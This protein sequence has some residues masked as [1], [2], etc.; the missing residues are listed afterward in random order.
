MRTRRPRSQDK[1]E[2][3]EEGTKKMITFMTKV[4]TFSLSEKNAGT[5]QAINI[6]DLS[7]YI[8]YDKREGKM[9]DILTYKSGKFYFCHETEMVIVD[10]LLFKANLLYE[11]VT[12]LPILP[13]MSA[14]LDPKI[15]YSSISGTAMIEGNP[16]E[17]EGVK[18]IAAGEE[19]PLYTQKDKQEIKN[20]LSL[21]QILSEMEPQN[22][23]LI[24]SEDFIKTMHRIITTEIPHEYNIPGAYRNGEVIVGDKGHGGVYRPPKILADV[25]MLMKEFVAWLNSEEILGLNPF[26]RAALAHYH[27]C[28]IHPFW[29]GNGRTARFLESCLLHSANIKYVPKELSNYYYRNVDDYYAAFSKS[30]KNRKDVTPFIQFM[31]EGVVESLMDIKE[32]ITFLIRRFALRDFYTHEQKNR[33]ISKRQFAL[34]S[35]LL[36]NPIAFTLKDLMDNYPFKIL[37]Q[38]ASEQTAR[39]DIKKLLEKN[40]LKEDDAKKYE[41]NYRALG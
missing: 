20:L 11:T 15:M 1:F 30:I 2:C 18:K 6:I 37:Y 41:L 38:K 19:M 13:G 16:I 17:E 31:L 3:Y 25:K 10:N 9:K 12:D 35:L 8:F 14:R 4:V 29:D 26:L 33:A 22:G 34:L 5:L 7:C 21:Y 40:L 36:D 32:S 28:L 39:R 27:L 24:V 23:P